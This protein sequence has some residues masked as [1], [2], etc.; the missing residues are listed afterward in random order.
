MPKIRLGFTLIE[1]MITIG[2]IAVLTSS[3]FVINITG[4][5]QKGRDGRRQ[6]D[7][8]IERSAL[9]R[10]RS[11]YGYYP[12]G[13]NLLVTGGYVTVLPT[14]PTQGRL[15]PY[16]PSPAGCTNVGANRC[17]TYSLC[18]GLEKV[19]TA[20]AGCGSCGS[21]VTCSYKTTNP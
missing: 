13:D 5:L 14:D 11:D 10:Y 12:T 15:Y 1:L 20:Q 16:S 21:G 18:A 8:E 19:V 6:A 3:V 2:I 17:L 4:N 9:E 7:L